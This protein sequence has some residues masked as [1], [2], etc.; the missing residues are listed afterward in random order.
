MPGR[1]NIAAGTAPGSGYWR[2]APPQAGGTGS[3]QG[4]SGAGTIVRKAGEWHPTVVHLVGLVILETIAYGL[5][6]YVF[7]NAHGG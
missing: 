7:R 6:R 1:F 4:P 3:M 5:L 2:G